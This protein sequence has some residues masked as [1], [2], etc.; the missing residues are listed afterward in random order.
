MTKVIGQD[1]IC[2]DLAAQ[3]R[4][5]LALQQRGKPIGVFL[6][7]GHPGTGKTYLGKQLATELGRKL[8]HL[9][10][11]QFSRGMGATVLLHC[12]C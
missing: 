1:A 12:P 2:E 5:R 6:F 9:D 4:R 8:L 11:T 7:A 10:M 3:I